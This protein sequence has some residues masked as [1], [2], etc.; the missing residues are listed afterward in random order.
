VLR[1]TAEE[2]RVTTMAQL[3]DPVR[4]L[5]N[6]YLFTDLNPAQIQPLADRLAVRRFA[7]GEYIVRAGEESVALYILVTGQVREIVPSPGGEEIVNE[8][9]T[10][11]DVFGEAGLFSRDRTRIIHNVAM[12]DSAVAVIE[13]EALIDF[14]LR[15]PP[16]MLRM[17][18]GL[19]EYVRSTV[20]DQANLAFRPIRERLAL[21]LLELAA[22][23]PDHGRAVRLSQ[24]TLAT[25]I[26]STRENVNRSLTKLAAEGYIHMMSGSIIVVDPDGLR[27]L[28][29][30]AAPLLPPPN[31]AH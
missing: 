6:T 17:L 14:L 22:D 23:D 24:T 21:Q 18:Q 15:H 11:G 29:A 25:M 16:A 31:R 19:A 1:V 27:R 3:A 26:G 4:L 28:A 2:W 30:R 12:V 20:H 9:Y 5:L 13:R 8:L 7:G 10:A